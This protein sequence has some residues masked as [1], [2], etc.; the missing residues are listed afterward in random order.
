MCC[1]HEIPLILYATSG[2]RRLAED[3][4]LQTAHQ[5]I[6]TPEMHRLLIK[7]LLYQRCRAGISRHWQ[8]YGCLFRL[9]S[10]FAIGDA[11]CSFFVGINP[12]AVLKAAS[13][14][15]EL[16]TACQQHSSI[17]CIFTISSQPEAESSSLEE[18][19]LLLPVGSPRP[20]SNI[21]ASS[22][23]ACPNA[24]RTFKGVGVPS[25]LR[26]CLLTHS[27]ASCRTA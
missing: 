27:L 6:A 25:L 2:K 11:R 10:R 17:A 24:I 1:D 21:G 4:A 7:L 8:N 26:F 3:L 12:F 20:E 15:V 16:L 9:R 18:G 23:A 19:L 22:G 5:A 14:F 13:I